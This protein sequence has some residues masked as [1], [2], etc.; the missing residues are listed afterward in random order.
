[1]VAIERDAAGAEFVRFAPDFRTDFHTSSLGV[2]LAKSNGLVRVQRKA[3]PTNVLRVGTV[4]RDGAQTLAIPGT[5][6]GFTH[7]IIHCEVAEYNF[8]AAP[9]K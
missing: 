1:M 7:V 5:A 8:G 9:L 2:H 6:A 4:T 3:D